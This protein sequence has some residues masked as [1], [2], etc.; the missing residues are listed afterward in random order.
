MKVFFST[1]VSRSRA[2]LP[3]TQDIAKDIEDFGFEVLT[4]HLVDPNYTKDPQWHRQFDPLQLYNQEV[5]RLKSADALIT[6]CTTP[7]F[8]AGFFIDLCLEIKKP[9][10]SLH[11]GLEFHNAPLM[12]QGRPEIN[13]QMYTEENIKG[14]LKHF[15]DGLVHH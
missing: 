3:V 12:L 2:I 13:L 9:L 11:Y 10:L 14:V 8:G 5:E 15:F 7:S 1:S 6:E 4:K